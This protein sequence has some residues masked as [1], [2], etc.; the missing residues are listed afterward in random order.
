MG[1]HTSCPVQKHVRLCILPCAASPT[2][3]AAEVC[4]QSTDIGNSKRPWFCVVRQCLLSCSYISC[5]G[6]FRWTPRHTDIPQLDIFLLKESTEFAALLQNFAI[7]TTATETL[8]SVLIHIRAIQLSL[9][10]F[11]VPILF[12]I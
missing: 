2:H 5:G 7:M 8:L 12:A 6:A 3:P 1:S 9:C 11:V 10:V 4:Q